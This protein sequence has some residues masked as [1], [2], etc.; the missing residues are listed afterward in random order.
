MGRGAKGAGAATTPQLKGKERSPLKWTR[1]YRGGPPEPASVL[2]ARCHQGNNKDG[3][4][5]SPTVAE[6]VIINISHPFSMPEKAGTP[7]PAGVSKSPCRDPQWE[8]SSQAT[9]S[10][11]LLGPFQIHSHP[12]PTPSGPRPQQGRPGGQ[13]PEAEKPGEARLPLERLIKLNR[14][15]S[16]ADNTGDATRS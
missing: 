15:G 6:A 4:A 16:C 1:V 12:R 11:A 2:L 14:A 9:N 13:R 8:S 5:Q 7:C 3:E 10:N